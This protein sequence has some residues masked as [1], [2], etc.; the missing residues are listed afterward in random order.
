MSA[1]IECPFCKH[2]QNDLKCDAFPEKIPTEILTGEI[3]HEKPLKNQKNKIVFQPVTK[4]EKTNTGTK[5]SKMKE[6]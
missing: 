3:S 1:T 5:P 2:Y 6:T 4:D